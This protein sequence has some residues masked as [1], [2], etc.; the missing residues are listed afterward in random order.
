MHREARRQWFWQ[1]W[2]P[3]LGRYRAAIID[4][5]GTLVLVKVDR[6]RHSLLS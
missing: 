6:A 2:K 3:L 4:D 5:F 1:I